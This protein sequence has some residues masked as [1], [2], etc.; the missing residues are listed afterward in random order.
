MS[1]QPIKYFVPALLLLGS[2]LGLAPVSAAVASQNVPTLTPLAPW[3]SGSMA[4]PDAT[5]PWVMQQAA[6][7]VATAR[8]GTLQP[9][10]APPRL[11]AIGGGAGLKREVFGF[12]L[13]SSLSDPTVGYP[14]W[15]FSLLS[16][17]AFFGLHVQDNGTFAADSGAAVWNSSQ[18]SGLLTT[19]HSHGVKVV[20]TIILQDFSAGTPH[21]CAGLLH[22]STTITNTVNEVKA[23]G[24]DGVNID[25][26]GLNGSCGHPDSSW[27]RHGFTSFA[28]E[29]RAQLPAGSYLSVDTYASS[30]ADSLGFFDVRGL[31][32]YVDSYF[33]MAYDL[34]YANWARTPTSCSRFCLGP[35]APLGGYYYNDT[36]TA[37]QYR[38]VVPASK[39][40]LGVPYYGRKSCV[41]SA[42]PNQYPSTSVV[43]DAYTD[44]SAEYTA[45]AVKAGSYAAHRDAKDPSGQER[46][47]VWVNTSLNCIREL[48]WDDAVSLSRKYDLVNRDNLRG[49][50]IWNL[51]YG[52]GAPALWSALNTYFSC[53]VTISVPA[54][55]TTTQFNVGISAGSCAAVSFDVEQ[56]DSTLNQG[57]FPLPS[58]RASAAAGAEIVNGY[59]G[60]AYQIR[61]RAHSSSGLVSS[62]ATATVQVSATATKSHAWSGLY[63]LDGYGGIHAVDSPPLSASAYW[64]GWRIAR[65]AHALPEIAV[66]ATGAVLDGYG[67]L[68]SYGAPIKLKGTVYWQ[69]WDIAR[70][71]AFLPSGTGGYVL[72]GFGGLHPF[73]VNG[74]AMPPAAK[75]F[76]YWQ[77]WDIARKVV[78]FSD[79]RGGYVLDAW[80]GVHGFGIGQAAPPTPKL[81]AYW[82]GWN[83][84]RG[85]ALVPGTHNGYVL[86]GYGGVHGF[87]PAGLAMPAGFAGATYWHGWDIARSI[88]L[89]PTSTPTQMAG[90]VMDGYGGLH[91]LG[92]APPISS[93]AYWHGWDIAVG[94]AGG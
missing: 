86:D 57:W 48:Y 43:A 17:V 20:L 25:Y 76:T 88:W 73:S 30:A 34:E 74:A 44:A 80:G 26:E 14:T 63:T 49:V 61:V 89:L 94:I 11:P 3:G 37:S 15:D 7:K 55:A 6:T 33:V 75:G 90:Y 84:A 53:P 69:G 5:H 38:S 41:T 35:T 62:W 70:D 77:G 83:I 47:D 13:A 64:Q 79:G 29:L 71:F 51:N 24:I 68:H 1:L 45:P 91:P 21:M 66:P 92:A 50:G 16:T 46:W 81:S 9:F 19:A 78:I 40:I 93:F 8:T 58:V 12:A 23:K 52:G 32:P 67:G 22:A 72:D 85:I 39:V 65:A 31:A 60:H 82:H 18:L 36:T 4:T 10:T 2:L 27:A 59:Q 42:T 28:G 56:Y 54:P 87:A